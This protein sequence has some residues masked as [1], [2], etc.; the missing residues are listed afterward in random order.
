[1]SDSQ[2]E[3]KAL[4]RRAQQGDSQAFE[5]LVLLHGA[6]VYN[7]ALR[8]LNHPQEAEDIAQEALVRAWQAL[9][10]FRLE[11]KFS[12]WLYRIVTNL[13]YNRLPT[14]KK[15]LLDLEDEVGV[16]ADKRPLPEQALLAQFTRQQLVEAI[17]DLPE[18]Y[19]LLITLRHVQ[20]LSYQEIAEVAELPLGTVKTGI[21][22]ARKQLQ[23]TLERV[24]V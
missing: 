10:R 5:Q 17:V 21:H 1:M 20:G 12:T 24:L 7:L 9:P 3:E 14:L 11:S 23:Q 2:A 4:I 8:T 22:R 19:R 16:L 6:Y 13:C 15:N 18:S